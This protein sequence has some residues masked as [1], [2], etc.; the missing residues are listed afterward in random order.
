MDD[1][2]YDDD[3]D[4]DDDDSDDDDDERMITNNWTATDHKYVHDAHTHEWPY[5]DL[6]NIAHCL[7]E[8]HRLRAL[9]SK[10]E[11]GGRCAVGGAEDRRGGAEG[12]EWLP[13]HYSQ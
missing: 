4:D 2:D 12:N 11:E 5:P 10:G 8:L 7:V 6:V 13:A 3:D 1:D 9:Q